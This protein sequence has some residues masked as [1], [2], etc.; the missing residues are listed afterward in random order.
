M[1]PVLITG[2]LGFAGRHIVRALA[3]SGYKLVSYNRD[4]SE[5]DDPGHVIAVQGE[6]FDIPRL[7]RVMQEHAVE[8]VV[9]T[10][11]MSHPTLSLD[12][13]LATFAANV[14]G[15]LGVLEASRLAG[16]RRIV[17]FSSETVYGRVDGP[18]TEETPFH[19]TTP[20]AVTKMATEWLGEMHRNRYDVTVI[21][22]RIAQVYGPGNAMPEILGDMLKSVAESGG[23]RAARGRDHHFNFIYVE[24]VAGA[25]LAA[26]VAPGPLT[27]RA[28]NV[29]ST[30]YWALGDVVDLIRR[31]ILP[32]ADIEI[33]PGLVAELDLQG[34]FDGAA[35]P[36]TAG[37]RHHGPGLE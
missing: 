9:H 24:D 31:E 26:L 15:T 6:L 30:E 33:G 1:G 22:L 21:S 3:A 23:F 16:V 19:P 14:D 29:S 28:Y 2:G 25:T 10:A 7:V 35:A 17:N 13:P 8:E 11:A 18:V 20:N 37:R 5:S 12:F 32:H 4:Y 34:P 36:C 27:K